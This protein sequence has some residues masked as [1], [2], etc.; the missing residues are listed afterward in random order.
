MLREIANC[1]REL[2]PVD[3]L[4]ACRRSK[5]TRLVRHNEGSRVAVQ[6][7]IA[8]IEDRTEAVT[9][10]RVH[11]EVVLAEHGRQ[12]E[13]LECL[14]DVE[15][16][17]ALGSVIPKVE[18]ESRNAVEGALREACEVEQLGDCTGGTVSS[19]SAS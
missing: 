17:H 5:V 16:C 10:E 13:R 12:A 8:E 9:S 15:D 11:D 18:S 6:Q 3:V 1:T 2:K 19:I 14:D 4:L 7:A